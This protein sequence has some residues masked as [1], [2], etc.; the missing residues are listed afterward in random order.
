MK[1]RGALGRLVGV[2]ALALACTCSSSSNGW[3]CRED[4]AGCTCKQGGDPN[5]TAA[6]SPSSA[7]TS[8]PTD[9]CATLDYSTG[10]QCACVADPTNPGYGTTSCADYMFQFYTVP[11]QK[12]AQCP[13]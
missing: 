12:V 5:P 1:I 13:P 6:G 9:C 7:C 8:T 11:Y 10:T 3:Q 4:S 2:G